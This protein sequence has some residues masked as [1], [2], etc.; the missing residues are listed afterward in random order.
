[1]LCSL[2]SMVSGVEAISKTG[3]SRP[4]HE[5]L[6]CSLLSMFSSVAAISKTGLSRPLHEDS[7]YVV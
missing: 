2:L 6:L 4:W 1:M 7:L 5:G 3:R